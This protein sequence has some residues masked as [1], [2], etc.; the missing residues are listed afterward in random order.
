MKFKSILAGMMIVSALTLTGCSGNTTTTTYSSSSTTT[1]DADGNTTSTSSETVEGKTL[2]T[3]T[4]PLLFENYSES[5]FKEIYIKASN[6][7]SYGDNLLD[8]D[9]V[10]SP[11]HEIKYGS[12]SFTDDTHLLDLRLVDVDGNVYDYYEYEL[13]NIID[14]KQ[15]EFAFETVE[16][17]IR[18]TL[19]YE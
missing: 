7:E 4:K 12:F 1:T 13:N 9:E 14:N 10:L 5:T 11:N 3:Y 16:G 8:E 18:V 19:L 15:V 17:G 6:Y 2:T